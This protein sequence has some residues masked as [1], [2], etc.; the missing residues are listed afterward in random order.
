MRRAGRLDAPSMPES[1]SARP[2]SPPQPS[3]HLPQV[4]LLLCD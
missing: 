4:S 3:W 2:G 1:S